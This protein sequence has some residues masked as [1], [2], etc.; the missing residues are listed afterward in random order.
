MKRDMNLVREI[1]IAVEAHPD[2]Q[3]PMD[4]LSIEGFSADEISYHVQI[5][6]EAGLLDAIDAS[7][8]DDYD[9]RPRR[10]TWQG[11]EFL[12]AVRNDT[13]WRKI[14]QLIA[15][16]GGAIPLEVVKTLAVNA[17]KMLFDPSL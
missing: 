15:E 12:A 6:A 4:P 14:K 7:S 11:Q 8:S 9:W 5:M 13:V 17:T 2:P 10:L 1:L 3:V 16:K